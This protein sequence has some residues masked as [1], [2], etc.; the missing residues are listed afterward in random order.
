WRWAA[1]V[2]STSIWKR[3]TA[4]PRKMRT[5]RDAGSFPLAR[6]ALVDELAGAVEDVAQ[7][8][9]RDDQRAVTG[10]RQTRVVTRAAREFVDF[11]PRLHLPD[12]NPLIVRGGGDELAVL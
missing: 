4:R 6:V 11:A 12:E 9:G 8:V 3:R 10:E 5:W 1:R 2:P 7:S